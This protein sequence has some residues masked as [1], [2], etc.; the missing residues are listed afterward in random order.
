Q[1][2]R[3]DRPLKADHVPGSV[4]GNT[5]PSN[6]LA[7]AA[8]EAFCPLAIRGEGPGTVRLG[9]T[10]DLLGQQYRAHRTGR[11]MP[12]LDVLLVDPSLGRLPG[13]I[14]GV[15]IPQLKLVFPVI[16]ETDDNVM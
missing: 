15:R 6:C 10:Q 9:D 13:H 8:R 5:N 4:Y 16:T 1:L 3:S 11:H 14:G 12:G 2:D 7:G